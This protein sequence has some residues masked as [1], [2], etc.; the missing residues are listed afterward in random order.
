MSFQHDE[1][2]RLLLDMSRAMLRKCDISSLMRMMISHHPATNEL[3][4]QGVMPNKNGTALIKRNANRVESMMKVAKPHFV[5]DDSISRCIDKMWND[6]DQDLTN[7]NKLYITQRECLDRIRWGNHL[8]WQVLWFELP[9]A[10]LND[11]IRDIFVRNVSKDTSYSD[12]LQQWW[13]DIH[14]RNGNDHDLEALCGYCCHGGQKIDK[15]GVLVSK[16]AFGTNDLNYQVFAYGPIKNKSKDGTFLSN[17]FYMPELSVT[18][19]A[20]GFLSGEDTKANDAK[21]MREQKTDTSLLSQAFFGIPCKTPTDAT[22]GFLGRVRRENQIGIYGGTLI[23]DA[24]EFYDIS[25][26][27]VKDSEWLKQTYDMDS[28]CFKDNWVG[29]SLFVV[30]MLLADL[31]FPHLIDNQTK[32]MTKRQKSKQTKKG[33]VISEKVNETRYESIWL[34]RPKGVSIKVRNDSDRESKAHLKP[35]WFVRNHER[36]FPTDPV[37][38][39]KNHDPKNERYDRCGWGDVHQR[40]CHVIFVK[41]KNGDQIRGNPKHGWIHKEHEIRWNEMPAEKQQEIIRNSQQVEEK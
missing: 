40:Y 41:G 7:T 10:K 5:R 14:E 36:H 11:F 22:Y 29:L 1:T 9:T 28:I 30:N 19:R 20:A 24:M 6:M 13:S 15:V 31:N 23:R 2:D 38:C 3:V 17:G 12:H 37:K 21:I 16:G 26:D 8:P 25:F 18:I 4:K 33:F 35:A 34:P 32:G 27:G 39:T